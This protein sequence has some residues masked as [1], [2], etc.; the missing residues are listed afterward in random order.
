KLDAAAI[1]L[2][3]EVVTRLDEF[4]PCSSGD[5]GACAGDFI[6]AFAQKAYRRPI[7]EDEALAL[8]A[9]F[10][11]GATDADYAAGVHQVVR[12]ILQSPGF[13][14]ITEIGDGSQ[15]GT[16]RM[17]PHETA[18]SMAFFLTGGPP[19][20]ALLAAAAGGNLATAE[21]RASEARRLLSTEG[22]SS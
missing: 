19:D 10:Q 12:G 13:L 2:A 8:A 4:A 7:S 22:G 11:A 16:V 20:D 6:Y 15:T 1:A 18:S 17:T 5:Y 3:S 9:L 14:Y 21:G